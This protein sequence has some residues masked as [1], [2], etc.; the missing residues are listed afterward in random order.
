LN[1]E[2]FEIGTNVYFRFIKLLT[3]ER[4]EMLRAVSVL[5]VKEDTLHV[6]CRFDSE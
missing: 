1:L 5:F 2:E 6:V 4:F 3:K